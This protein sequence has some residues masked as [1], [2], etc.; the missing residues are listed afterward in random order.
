M[1]VS[2][3]S[4]IYREAQD[5]AKKRGLNLSSVIEDFLVRFVGKAKHASDNAVPD[6]VLSLLGAGEPVAEED[7]N[8]REAYFQYLE[9]KY[10]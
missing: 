3:D 8:A 5:Y 9:N 10:Q 4:Q 7:I 1:E 6:V 2:I